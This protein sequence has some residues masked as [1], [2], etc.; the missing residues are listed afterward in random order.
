MQSRLRRPADNVY[1]G[2]IRLVQAIELCRE[3]LVHNFA[4]EFQCGS[5]LALKR[6]QSAIQQEEFLDLCG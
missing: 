4:L 6:G 5:E 1:D 2:L 3:T